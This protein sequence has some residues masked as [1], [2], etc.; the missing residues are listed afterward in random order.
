MSEK[1]YHCS[2][3]G[4]IY[5]F[6]VQSQNLKCPNCG[7]EE[8]IPDLGGVGEH[9]LYSG[10]QQYSGDIQPATESVH[11][12]DCKSCGASIE[13]SE[14]STATSCPY[15]GSHIVL[16]HK[17][18]EVINP[19]GIRPFKIDK[20]RVGT[21]FRDWIKGKWLAPGELKTAYQQDKVM[22]VYVPYWTFDAH[23]D[24]KYTCDVGDDYQETYTDSEGKRQTR[25]KTRWSRSTGSFSHF[26]N[27]I[28]IPATKA[29]KDKLLRAVGVYDTETLKSYSPAYLS[30]FSAE[31]YN[32]P[33]DD[34]YASAQIEMKAVL[35]DMVRNIEL[36]RHDHVA[37]I[38]LNISYADETFKHVILPVFITAYYFKGNIY[39]VIIN[40][41]TGYIYGEY[42]KSKFKIFL[43]V[44]AVLLLIA[45]VY[46]YSTYYAQ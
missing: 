34:A 5:E 14:D 33:I 40:G 43:I 9:P 23:T 7:T 21:I 46:L 6:N 1:I 11:L 26:F 10:M 22:G 19:D 30:G 37:N 28:L 15:C 27:D 13:V 45:L 31:R 35:K 24:V 42:P 16:E 3:C 17:Q 4:G 12:L 2:N 20:N 38:F 8:E 32:V 41:E 25:T 29:I 39:N 18:V 44:L 36:R